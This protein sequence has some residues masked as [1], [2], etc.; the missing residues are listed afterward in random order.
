MPEQQS[1]S[2]TLAVA[3][4]PVAEGTRADV[5]VLQN[6]SRSRFFDFL[7]SE[8]IFSSSSCSTIST[9]LV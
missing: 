2:P 6:C 5:V 8:L 4:N 9:R 7:I 1:R 3:G